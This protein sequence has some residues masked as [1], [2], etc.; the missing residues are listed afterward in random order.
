ML[1][2]KFI[3]LDYFLGREMISLIIDATY[4]TGWPVPS[5]DQSNV[6]TAARVGLALPPTPIFDVVHCFLPRQLLYCLN[7]RTII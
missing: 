1:V 4:D 2:S 6:L 7:C 3:S 5:P